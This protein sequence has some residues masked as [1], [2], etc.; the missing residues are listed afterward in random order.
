V[1]AAEII[2]TVIAS[3]GGAGVILAALGAWLGQVWADRLS[4]SQR[5]LG[6]IDLDLRRRRIDA[7]GP[8]WKSTGLLPQ[9][10]RAQ[11]ITYEHLFEFSG[12]LRTWY[13]DTGGIYL[14]STSHKTGY[15]PLQDGIAALQRQHK[16]GALSDADYDAIRQLC[17]RLRSALANDIES[18]REGP[19]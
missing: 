18:R 12:L 10:P 19:G 9:W 7:Y 13:Y 4:Q 5:L 2:L 6:E 11:G 8:L 1:S 16:T 14:S 3:A 15:V 17:S